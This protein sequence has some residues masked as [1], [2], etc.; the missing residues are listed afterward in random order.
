MLDKEKV[1]KLSWLFGSITRHD[2]VRDIDV[3][4]H[5]DP[6]L[7]FSEY[8]DFNACVE[9]KLGLPVDMVEI[10]KVPASLKERI[11]R[12]G[13]LIKGTKALQERL[14]RESV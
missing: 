2:T 13:I 1:V 11:Y 5:A 14:Q 7:S 3:A 8:L 6:E 9:L 10:A 4:I 12:E